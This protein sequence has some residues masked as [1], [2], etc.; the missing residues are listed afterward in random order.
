MTFSNVEQIKFICKIH[1]IVKD[2]PVVSGVAIENIA[3][4]KSKQKY[5][6]VGR[7]RVRKGSLY[8]YTCIVN[9]GRRF[10]AEE[11]W[12]ARNKTGRDVSA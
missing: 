11:G 9:K 7:P 3:L 5:R 4:L 6:T 10:S 8:I 1:F 2:A 12:R